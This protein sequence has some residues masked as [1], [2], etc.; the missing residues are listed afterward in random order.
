MTSTVPRKVR[1]GELTAG[2]LREILGRNPVILL[3]LGSHED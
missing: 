2:E 3:P 1:L